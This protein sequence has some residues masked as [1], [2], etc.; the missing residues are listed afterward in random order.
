MSTVNQLSPEVLV[1]EIDL[2]N[3]I[4]N[5]GVSG[6]AFVGNFNWGEALSVKKIDNSNELVQMFG[7]PDDANY[8]DWFS[9][10]NFLSYSSGLSLVRVVNSDDALNSDVSGDGVLVENDEKLVAFEPSVDN[11]HIFIAKCPGNLGNSLAIS[12]ADAGT[13]DGWAYEEDFDYAPGT[14]TFAD[15]LGL[16][17]DEVHVVVFDRDGLFSGTPGTILEK[18]AFLSKAKDAKGLDGDLI[19]YGTVINNQSQYIRYIDSMPTTVFKSDTVDSV[20]ITTAGTGYPADTTITFAASPL[21][22]DYTARGTVTVTGGAISAVTVTYQGAGYSVAPA[23]TVT[24]S[25]GS[26]AVLTA[27]LGKGDLW[28]LFALDSNGIPRSFG[29]LSAAYTKDLAGGANGTLPGADEIIEG[30]DLF[31]DVEKAD[32][33]LLFVGE[34]GGKTES[35]AVIQHAIDNIAENRKDCLVFYSPDFDD[36]KNKTQTDAVTAVVAKKTAIGRSSSYAVMDS[37]WKLQY[38]Q[39]NDKYR[40]IPLNP[41]V[42]GLCAK[43]D[44]DFDPWWSPAGYNRGKI[45]NCVSLAFNPNKTS[46]D[47]LYKSYINSVVTFNNDGTVLFGDR[48]TLAKPSVFGYINVRRLFITLEKAI[49]TAA[50]YQLFEFNN[51]FTRAQFRNMVEPYLREVKGRHGIYDFYVECSEKNNT[52]E[53]IDRAQFVASIFIKPARSINFIVLNFVAV[54]TGVEFSEVVGAV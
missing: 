23:I 29:Q 9:A 7:K 4:P 20:T 40:W 51:Q 25:G 3:F 32:A 42:A 31:E 34:A 47:S 21:G 44:T 12:I 10:Y 54:R 15:N 49:S 11:T 52:P 50:K 18:Y 19:F 53:V 33:N 1:R 24:G 16:E 41:D 5:V 43:T 39:Y 17:N 38:D 22:A 27:V 28:G 6:G 30:L 2:T 8:V 37:G 45:K 35:V 48:T 46:R 13:F 14:S 26:N 36:V